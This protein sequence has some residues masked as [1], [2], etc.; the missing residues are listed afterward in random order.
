MP[1]LLVPIF[2]LPFVQSGPASGA[3]PALLAA[4]HREIKDG[5]VD[6]SRGFKH[7]LVDLNGDGRA[8]AIVLLQ[9]TYWCGSGG[10]T[11]LVFRGTPGGF[12]SV[13]RSTITYEPI[14]VLSA[15]ANGWKTLVVYS[16]GKGA[17]VMRFNGTRYPLNPSLQPK[18]TRA[19]VASAQVILR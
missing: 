14:R 11:M 5:V 7:A 12:A 4:I 3:P 18:A 1:F 9:G 10:C 13:S 6:Q 16:K 17:V 8:D 19:E 15:K 2:A